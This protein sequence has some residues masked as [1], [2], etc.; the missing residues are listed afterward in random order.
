M[1]TLTLDG[2]QALLKH[3]NLEETIASFAVADIKSNPLDIYQ[4][5]LAEILVRLTNCEEQAAYDS[6]LLPNESGDLTVVVP[7]LRLQ[8]IK[9]REVVA[10]LKQKFPPSP[11][12]ANPIDDGIN[13]RLWFSPVTLARLLIPYIRDRGA[14]YGKSQSADLSEA[15]ESISVPQ[16]VIVEF[17]SP[18][19]GKEFDGN[20][21]RSTVI[22]AYIASI[23]QFMGWDVCRMNFLGDWGRHIGLLAAG[24]S[25]F[26][27][28][29]L[30]K[31]N[32]LRHLLDV[33]VQ[34]NDLLRHE[35]EEAKSRSSQDQENVVEHSTT[36]T[37]KDELFR[38]LEDGDP[39]ALA[40]W[41][42]FREACVTSYTDLYARLNIKFDH[43]SGESEVEAK[44]IVEVEEI[45]KEKDA[46]MESDGAWVIDFE[47][48]GY[49]GQRAAIARFSNG[50]T[51]YLLRDIAAVLER[52]NRY[53][54][55]KMIYV[56]SAKQDTHFRQVFNALELMGH[57]QLASKLQHVSFGKF[58]GLSPRPDSGGLLL[59]DILDQCQGAFEE[60][61]KDN[62]GDFA[63]LREELATSKLLDN[64]TASGL[65]TQELSI[66]R[67]ST[68]TYDT[69]KMAD[70][71]SDTGL[72]LQYWFTKVDS[73]LKGVRI[74][75]EELD[76]ADYS[77][78]TEDAFS[79]ILRLLIQFPGIVKSSFKN[80]ESSTIVTYLFQ[81]TDA[82]DG[83]LGD[84]EEAECSNLNL[85]KLA[86]FECVRQTLENGMQ[87][88]GLVPLRAETG[89]GSAITVALETKDT[90][91]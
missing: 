50:S 11:L 15:H 27:S 13:L 62:P 83:V 31:K 54:F 5:R 90:T 30:L 34:V 12:F 87:M 32:P 53:S 25:R 19:V 72:T 47:K 81:L 80:L 89:G 18:N 71:N 3:L 2:I 29:E 70:M 59:S 35:Q 37:E 22:G 43:Y 33:F 45:L 28:E 36:S 63:E 73:K 91:D 7:R 41:T 48:H 78:F 44:T 79:D 69:A 51:S 9:P 17:C 16:K 26:G 75:H 60:F 49:K 82:L 38:R 61:L 23:Y 77:I 58:Q 86:F 46:Y 4:C 6:I 8:N 68:F 24:W 66:K 39:D 21:L 64:L 65:M 20:H 74:V 1:A 40:I 52:R 14:S 42:M 85:A 88:V 10:D 76:N 84:E 67:G 55:D 57:A 56:V